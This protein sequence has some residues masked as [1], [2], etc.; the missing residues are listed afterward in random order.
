[1]IAD[2]PKQWVWPADVRDRPANVPPA[3]EAMR[4]AGLPPSTR[5]E[6]CRD[7][8]PFPCDE[9]RHWRCL[10]AGATGACDPG[11]LPPAIQ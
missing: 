1:M 9:G 6:F 10:R 2:D 5:C 7:V 3:D 11:L 4:R 8:V